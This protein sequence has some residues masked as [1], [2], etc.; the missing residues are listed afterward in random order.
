M[1]SSV[2]VNHRDSSAA[3]PS[4]AFPLPCSHPQYLWQD[5]LNCNTRT[6]GHTGEHLCARGMR[7]GTSAAAQRCMPRV[8]RSQK[9][10][11]ARQAL[12]GGEFLVWVGSARLSCSHSRWV[13]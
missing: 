12:P 8:N 6:E 5:W 11:S 13:C 3:T 2:G 9:P 1:E 4:E 7:A 10:S